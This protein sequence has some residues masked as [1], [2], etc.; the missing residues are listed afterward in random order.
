MS[1][2]AT[3]G[4]A[5]S[6]SYVTL[7]YANSFFENWL[8]P[9]A[10]DSAT[11]NDQSRA[12]MTATSWLEEFDYA[13]RPATTTQALKFPAV[14][15]FDTNG[16]LVADSDGTPALI[17][18]VYNETVIPVPLMKANCELAFYL[19]SLGVAASSVLAASAGPVSELRIGKS[20]QVK[21]AQMAADSIKV[22][23]P[24]VDSTGLPIHVARLLRGL[25]LPVVIA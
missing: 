11:P 24:A 9:N 2:D 3:V 21:Y 19:L 12:L 16:D 22:T 23:G 1:L 5:N 17:L 10:W 14:S 18:G 20:V 4:G 7:A 6:N 8:L 25:R 13:S 15:I